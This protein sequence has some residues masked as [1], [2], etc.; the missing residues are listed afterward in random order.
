MKLWESEEGSPFPL[1]VRWIESERSYN[2]AVYS[3]HAEE[4]RLLLYARRARTGSN[5]TEAQL[6]RKVAGTLRVPS[7]AP[8]SDPS[9]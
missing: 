3:K 9:F 6:A 1:G 8:T 5:G 2:F 7:A 4:V